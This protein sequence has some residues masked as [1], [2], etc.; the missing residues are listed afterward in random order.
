MLTYIDIDETLLRSKEAI[1]KSYQNAFLKTVHLIDMPWF[2]RYL[3]NRPW[4][5]LLLGWPKDVL[6]QI[7]AARDIHGPIRVN[8]DIARLVNHDTV[9]IT[10][11]SEKST[12]KKFLLAGVGFHNKILY[13]CNKR[14]PDFWKSLAPGLLIDDDV[15]ACDLAHKAGFSVLHFRGAI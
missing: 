7:Y 15:V 1:F 10:G 14:S 13:G 2:D 9:L 11:G 5:G 3:W 6:D 12:L 4:P 8:E